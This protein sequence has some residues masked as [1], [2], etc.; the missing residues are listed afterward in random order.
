[1]LIIQKTEQ[2]MIDNYC[3]TCLKIG[4][5]FTSD[6][7]NKLYTMVRHQTDA[8]FFCFT[9][10]SEG[11]I[12]DVNI[13]DIDLSNYS[14]WKTWPGY[15]PH[16]G[17]WPA[18]YKICLFSA[19]ELEKFERKI[20]FDL[21]VIIHG[22]IQPILHHD[23]NFSTI[24]SKWKGVKF[25]LKNPTNSI[26]NSSV[27]VW[28][29]NKSVYDYWM[30]K[31]RIFTEIYHGPDNFCHNEG[32]KRTPLPNICYSYRDGCKPDQ[33]NSLIMREEYALAILHQ[34]PKNH[35]L[36]LKEHPIVEYWNG[37]KPLL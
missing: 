30:K 22:N 33:E 17:W 37:K 28:K 16:Y 32:I 8:P 9:D 29:N 4:D 12:N 26:Y 24:Y 10:N 2:Q 11:I 14:T 3:I 6:Y 1:M 19:P 15:G 21:D 36:D 13:V 5:K 7:V 31:P 25:K 23:E 27:M 35:Q 18:W 20:F 34:E